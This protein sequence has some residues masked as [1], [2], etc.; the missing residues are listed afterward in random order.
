MAQRESPILTDAKS[1][2]DIAALPFEEALKQLESIV[3]RLERGDVPL[4]ESIDIYTRGEALK[5]RCDALLKQ[6]EA[7]IEK[8]TLGAHS[9]PAG[10]APLDVDK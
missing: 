2:S 4:E 8:I 5:A 6:A 1:N 3:A 10:T 7:R 9:K